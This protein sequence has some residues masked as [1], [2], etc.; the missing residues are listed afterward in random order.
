MLNKKYKKPELLAP[1]G[2]WCTLRTAVESGADSVYFGV[3]GLNMRNLA[4]NFDLL[5]LKK[6]MDFLHQQGKRGY[7]ALNVIVYDHELS[8]VKKILK[9]AKAAKVDAVIL[10]DLAVLSLARSLGLEVH[11]STQASIANS[12]SLSL[13]SSLGAKRVILARECG[14]KDIKK[15]VSQIEK[16]GINCEIEC[17]IHG[18]MCV[19]ISGRCFLSQY[20]FNKS[21]NRGECLQPCRREFLIRDTQDDAEYILGR[22]YVLSPKDLC[23]IDFI[24]RL[25]ESGIS[26]FKIEGRMRSP[27]YVR[28]VT[29]CYRRAIDAFFSG[30]L[31]DDLKQDLKKELARVYNRGFSRGFYFD[32]PDRDISRKLGTEYEKVFLGEVIRFY[33]KISVAEIEVKNETLHCGDTV[34]CTGPRTGTE[35]FSCSQ[36]EINHFP[37]KQVEKGMRAGIKL[38][39]PA[40]PGD[41]IFLWRKKQEI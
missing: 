33:K 8:L 13:F 37:V 35:I 22:D 31:N 6:I 2:N 32:S 10:W 17:F 36:I 15:I 23:T 3:K 25:I 1:A 21:A 24:D 27:E 40:R 39:F 34:L 5:E 26:S 11:V 14:L 7:L 12:E 38:E 16:K 41:R 29:S 19:S 9:K 20:S 28:I 4:R 30:S 18:A